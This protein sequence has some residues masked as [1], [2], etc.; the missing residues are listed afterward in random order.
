MSELSDP[1]ATP[2]DMVE[3]VADYYEP[4]C[5]EAYEDYPRRL[6]DLEELPGLAR[7]F[8]SLA[9]FMAEVVLEPPEHLCR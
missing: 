8:D 2:V 6:R 3:A 9:E 5:R 1:A 7:G 4:V